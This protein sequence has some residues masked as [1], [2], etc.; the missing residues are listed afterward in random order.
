MADIHVPTSEVVVR[1]HER[2]ATTGY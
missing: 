1:Q 2:E